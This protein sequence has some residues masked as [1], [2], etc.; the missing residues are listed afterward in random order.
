MWA[1]LPGSAA[2]NA[3]TLWTSN[4]GR[5]PGCAVLLCAAALAGLASLSGCA[6]GK[7]Q[8][9]AAPLT[10]P[11]VWPAPPDP[12]RVATVQC[13]ARPAD[14]GIKVSTWGKFAN[15]VT[16]A[17]KGNEPLVK[18]FAVAL[19][20]SDNLCLTDTAA[21]AVCCLDRA[22][23]KRYRWDR[24]GKLRFVSP[25]AIARHQG[26]FFVADSGLKAV[27]AFDQQGRLSFLI[28][29]KLEMP[30]SL[31]VSGGRLLVVDSHRH[32]VVAFDLA[33]HYLTE[34]GARGAGPGQFNFPTH[35]AVDGAGD[36]YITDS[37]NARVQRWSA[38][39]QFK[40]QIGG[41]GN[42]PGFF[43]RPK[44]VA[45]DS[46][47]HIYVVDALFDKLQIFDPDGRL[48]LILGEAGSK[49]GEFWLPNG[50]AISRQNEIFVADTYNRRVQVFKY[51][52]QP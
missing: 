43:G 33:G 6:T 13:I 22:Q 49:P 8:A 29:N 28:T 14:L 19:D 1:S 23:K 32:C 27:V 26:T 46:F 51:I 40:N 4:P 2:S 35:I 47:G 5:R 17:D 45:V 36:L 52:G 11:Q 21:N 12:P 44:G 15:W 18:P 31:A 50:I 48:L 10:P 42:S 7:S 39:G 20:E 16:G 37:I 30:V 9:L 24:I 38:T 34:F 41:A 25:V 3:S